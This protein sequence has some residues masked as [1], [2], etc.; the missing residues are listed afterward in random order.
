MK[1]ASLPRILVDLFP[2]RDR[3]LLIGVI[4]IGMI[5]AFFETL[6]VASIL[7]FMT[8]VLDPAAIER[9]PLFSAISRSVGATSNRE[10]LVLLGI[11]TAAVV[12]IGNIAAATN[13]L[14]QERFTARTL[15]RLSSS[16]FEGY[17]KQPYAFHVQRDA[18][19]LMKIVLTDVRVVMSA[20]V[21]PVFAAVSRIFM[22]LG[23]LG[24]L[25]A[26]D[27]FVAVSVVL[28]LGATYATVFRVVRARQRR[29][30]AEMNAQNLDRQRIV[31][32]GLGGAKELQMLGRERYVAERFE[33][34]TIGVARAEAS[35][36]LNASL[37]RYALE[38]VSFVGIL[39]V[40]VVLLAS[41]DRSAQSLVPVLALYAFAGYRLLPALQQIFSSAM[42]IRFYQSVLRGMHKDFLAVTS[43]PTGFAGELQTQ[44]PDLHFADTIQL[45]KVG[46]SYAGGAAPS[47]RDVNLVIRPKESIG[48]VGR[49]GAGK[50]TLA[51]II[52]GLY[53]PSAGAVTVDGVSLKGPAMRAWRRRVGYVPQQVFLANASVT[54]NIAFALP[55]SEIDEDAVLRAARLAQAD[56]FVRALPDGFDTLV[57]ERG[58]KLSGGQ[59]QRIGIARALYHEPEVLVFDEATSALDGLTEDAVMEA[60]RSLSGQRTIILVAHRLR[61]VEACDR[62][63]LMEEGRILADG[64]Y[65]ELFENSPEFRSLVGSAHAVGMEVKVDLGARKSSRN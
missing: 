31:Q 39:L 17:L 59:R 13:V 65:Q 37:P 50:T 1:T 61:T 7:P 18:P 42:T 9:Y 11:A 35:N 43:L 57:G 20:C 64:P 26:Q 63:V 60:I 36:R 55:R 2:G 56:E 5:S 12:T 8:F 53:E 21:S 45:Q 48:L 62:I 46:F 10:A 28:I 52:L 49:T 44:A 15:S 22:A 29:L 51:D 16:L 24:I 14:V 3:W 19:S 4:T 34:A 33:T 54:E 58:V 32:E 41:G 25:C 30:G 27:P 47:L 23:I 6:G 38:T 40:T